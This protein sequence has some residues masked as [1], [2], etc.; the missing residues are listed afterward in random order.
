MQSST[1][2]DH[3][4]NIR[5]THKTARVPLLESIVFKDKAQALAE[6]QTM[7]NVVECLILQTCNRI[8]LYIV[9]EKGEETLKDTKQHL[10]QRSTLSYEE[11][12]KAIETALD[13]EAYKHLIRITSGLESM[14]IG[15]EQVLNQVWDAYLEAEKAKTLGPILK[16]L[17]NRAMTVGRRIRDA[18][19][20]SKGAVS[21]GSASVELAANLLD[22]LDDKKILVMGAGETGTI[23]AKA[24]A[25]RCLSP[26]LFANRTYSRAVTLAETLGGE[27][28]RF[29]KFQ[30]V[31][32]NADVVICATSAPHLL[33]TKEIVSHSMSKRTSQNSLIIID[34]SNP[35]NVEKSVQELSNVNLYTI[36]DLHLIA[37]KNLAERQKCV[38]T[39]C[40][41]IDTELVIIDDDLKKLSVRLIISSLLSDAEQIRQT[42]LAKAISKLG[43]VDDKK[44]KVIDDLTSVLLKQTFL[45]VIENL[46]IAAIKD[47]KETINIAIK[48]FDKEG[49]GF[50]K[51]A[52]E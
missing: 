18:T 7:E 16:H 30:E 9:S 50:G 36:D 22:K 52:K 10:A 49:N 40:N 28:V 41:M 5:I 35:L 34:I 2:T 6:L 3:I 33:L 12:F 1:K 37:E 51:D 46:R 25:R 45:P 24:L 42:E 39:A 4:I 29:D 31:L 15:E 8:E 32:V 21:V 19:G 13:H 11:A 43:D 26:I 38:E 47:D 14:V 44:R 48:L 20:I 23:V 27:A 17:F